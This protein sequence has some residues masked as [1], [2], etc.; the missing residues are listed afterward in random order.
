MDFSRVFD[1]CHGIYSSV[2]NMAEWVFNFLSREYTIPGV[3][4]FS[5]FEMM[6]GAGLVAIITWLFVKFV[7]P[8]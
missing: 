8:T 5:V 7:L 4:S 2:I 3:G 1:L 6:F